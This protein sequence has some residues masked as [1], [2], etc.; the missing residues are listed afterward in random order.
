MIT[1]HIHDT[2]LRNTNLEEVGTL[3]HAGTYKQS[4]V[5]AADNG[6]I[7][8]ARVFVP[9]EPFSGGDEVVKDVLLLHLCAGNVPFFSIFAS[10]TQ[11]GLCIDATVLEEWNTVGREVR[12]H[13][14]VEATVGIEVYRVLSV[15]LQSFLVGNEEWY[16]G[17][18]FTGVEDLLADII[19]LPEF[20]L[21]CRVNLA[22]ACGKIVL[23]ITCRN[24]E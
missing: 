13:G 10:A 6:E 11:A 14:D 15:S 5:R 23:V 16:S 20:D 7:V 9:D 1:Q 17:S 4:A 19:G 22:G 21:W 18:V 24:S 8:L 12:R 2:D 3:G